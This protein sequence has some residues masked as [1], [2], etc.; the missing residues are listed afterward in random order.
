MLLA[1]TAPKQRETADLVCILA[2]AEYPGVGEV[3]LAEAMESMQHVV[4]DLSP[5]H[6][7]VKPILRIIMN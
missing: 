7:V 3:E 4:V 5:D 2:N 1:V 6:L